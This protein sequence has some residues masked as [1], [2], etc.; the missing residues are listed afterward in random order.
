MESE[1]NID[2]DIDEIIS[3]IDLGNMGAIFTTTACSIPA[4]PL[5]YEALL[6]AKKLLQQGYEPYHYH[7]GWE[8]KMR[9]LFGY[10]IRECQQR[11]FNITT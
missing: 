11:I 4:K 5:T 3:N 6:E 10:K 7:T 2:I 9:I 1:S 8:I